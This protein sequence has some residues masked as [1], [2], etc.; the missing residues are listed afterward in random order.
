[1]NIKNL[2]Q[3][4]EYEGRAEAIQSHIKRAGL[5]NERGIHNLPKL[6]HF[7][8]ADVYSL[9]RTILRQM[10]KQEVNATD[11]AKELAGKHNV[12]LNIVKGSGADGRIVKADVQAAMES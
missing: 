5:D 10:E 1:M 3:G 8:G 9:L 4:T 12:D 11:S 6:G 7:A 2:L